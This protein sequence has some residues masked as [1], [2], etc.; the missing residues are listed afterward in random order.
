MNFVNYQ[1]KAVKTSK[2][3]FGTSEYVTP[4]YLQH[5]CCT[6]F[7]AGHS[8]HTC[9][10]RMLAYSYLIQLV[11][12]FIAFPRECYGG[13]SIQFHS[14]LN[15]HS[16]G[17]MLNFYYL[18]GRAKASLPGFKVLPLRQFGTWGPVMTDEF[19]PQKDTYVLVNSFPCLKH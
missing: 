3:L 11:C 8:S 7:R 5:P 18:Y 17:S 1:A 2:H 4:S 14:F 13:Y 10:T 15:F 19:N 6:N 12:S 9:R 16:F